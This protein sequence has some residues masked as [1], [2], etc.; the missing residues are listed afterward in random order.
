MSLVWIFLDQVQC[1]KVSILDNIMYKN[2]LSKL[3]CRK[4]LRKQIWNWEVSAIRILHT[5]KKKRLHKC[6]IIHRKMDT[7]SPPATPRCNL[8]GNGFLWRIRLPT[9]TAPW[10]GQGEPCLIEVVWMTSQ[11]P[12]PYL[13]NLMEGRGGWK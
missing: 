1:M 8:R 7:S 11:H 9:N 5:H 12:P 6:G 2:L 3:K 10:N 13:S 4:G